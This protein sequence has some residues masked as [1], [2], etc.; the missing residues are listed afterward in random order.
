MLKKRRIPSIQSN[1][2]KNG[3]PG[4][5]PALCF[6]LPFLG[7][8]KYVYFIC[9]FTLCSSLYYKSLQQAVFVRGHNVEQFYPVAPTP[10]RSQIHH[11]PLTTSLTFFV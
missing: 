3:A 2:P 4:E 11:G 8:R 10:P 5:I 1:T 9:L 7:G 6:H